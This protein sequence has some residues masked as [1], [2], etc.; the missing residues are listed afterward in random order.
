MGLERKTSRVFWLH[1]EYYLGWKRR[2]QDGEERRDRTKKGGRHPN[3]HNIEEHEREDGKKST[4]IC[5]VRGE[6]YVE[7]WAKERKKVEKEVKKGEDQTKTKKE[8]VLAS[9]ARLTGPRRMTL[10]TLQLSNIIYVPKVPP[11]T[12]YRKLRGSDNDTSL[13]GR[14]RTQG[15]LTSNSFRGRCEHVGVRV[16][17][18]L[19]GDNPMGT[20][21]VHKIF[22][23]GRSREV[24]SRAGV[25]R[26]P[27][28]SR[29]NTT[30]VS[31]PPRS[32]LLSRFVEKQ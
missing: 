2:L 18:G 8:R 7:G 22:E 28:G 29:G 30:R 19:A 6:R 9:P 1:S 10:G 27:G 24:T 13:R 12:R 32:R 3:Q 26:Y 23:W 15:P 25:H 11:H 4:N 5:P 17:V 31:M 21:T 14:P 20:V 16:D